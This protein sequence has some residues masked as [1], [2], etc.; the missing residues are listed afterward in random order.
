MYTLFSLERI[1]LGSKIRKEFSS[2]K[3]LIEVVRIKFGN[4]LFKLV[5]ILSIF[6]MTI[7]LIAE[8]TAISLLIKYL[9]G[10]HLWITA[11]IVIVSSLLYTL[12]GGLRASILTD[13]FQFILFFLLLLISF[14]YLISINSLEFNFKY[15]K[16]G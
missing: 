15:I 8:V 3:T 7:F 9:S 13:K 5:L 14:A 1:F 2:G 10:T 4:Q 6:Y 12:Y 16:N 11:L